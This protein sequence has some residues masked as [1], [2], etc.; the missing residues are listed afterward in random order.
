M[1]SK[2]IAGDYHV[3]ELIGEGSFGKVHRGRR[4]CTGEI[5]AMKFIPKANRL[6]KELRSLQREIDIMR[7]LKHK[8]IVSLLDSFETSKENMQKESCFK[9]LKMMVICLWNRFT[10][11]HANLLR[12]C[13]TFMQIEFFIGI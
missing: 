3:L 11:L 5:V 2:K 9:F 12:H 6:E 8:N 4:I 10:V 7:R 1:E 13:T